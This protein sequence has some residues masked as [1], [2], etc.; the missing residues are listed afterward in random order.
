M[1]DHTVIAYGLQYGRIYTEQELLL[2]ILNTCFASTPTHFNTE[3]LSRFR[4]LRGRKCHQILERLVVGEHVKQVDGGYVRSSPDQS[5]VH[6]AWKGE[7]RVCTRD[8]YPQLMATLQGG[9]PDALRDERIAD[10]ERQIQSL[11]ENHHV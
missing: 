8:E 1:Q 3:R 7:W 9:T 10:L 11:K 5:K 2:V 4:S 6:F